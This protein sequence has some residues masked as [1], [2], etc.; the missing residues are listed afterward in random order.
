MPKGD[1]HVINRI[2]NCKVLALLFNL[3]NICRR[4]LTIAKRHQ[5]QFNSEHSR[6]GSNDRFIILEF[7]E[8]SRTGT[9]FFGMLF[10]VPPSYRCTFIVYHLFDFHLVF[11]PI[12]N[13]NNRTFISTLYDISLCSLSSC[14][15][16]CLALRIFVDILTV[17]THLDAS[18]AGTCSS[19]DALDQDM[20]C[21][22]MS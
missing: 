7:P 8:C 15:I 9:L 16:S 14:Q 17:P 20:F 18:Q 12:K 4:A 19:F 3:E 6:A 22:Y 2:T 1:C 11:I 10:Y 13:D 21:Y 5:T